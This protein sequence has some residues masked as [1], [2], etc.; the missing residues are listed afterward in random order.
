[1]L[2][3][4]RILQKKGISHRDI[5]PQN[6]LCYQGRYFLCDFDEAILTKWGNTEKSP[7]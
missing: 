6:I 7:D 1:M 5:K 3:T 2:T 4:L